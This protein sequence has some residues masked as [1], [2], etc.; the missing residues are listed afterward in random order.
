MS[1]FLVK[2]LDYLFVEFLVVLDNQIEDPWL[3]FFRHFK[4]YADQSA[5]FIVTLDTNN[6]C[7]ANPGQKLNECCFHFALKQEDHPRREHDFPQVE[8]SAANLTLLQN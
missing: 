8:F 5:I 7:V 4:N 3:S 1:D 2:S 6:A